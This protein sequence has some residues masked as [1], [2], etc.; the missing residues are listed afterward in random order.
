L[1]LIGLNPYDPKKKLVNIAKAIDWC[2]RFFPTYCLGKGL[3]YVINVEYFDLVFE[4]EIDAWSTEILLIEVIFL[5]LESVLYLVLAIGLDILSS[6]P[7]AM[8]LWQKLFFC[9]QRSSEHSAVSATPDDED[10]VE[11]Q[12]RVLDG[13]ANE[14]VIVMSELTKIYGNGKIAVDK[15]SLGIPPGECFGLLGTNGAG[16]V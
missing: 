10:V 11:E 2:G 12:K 9:F 1:R 7:E 3:L 15:L 14:D 13:N 4:E 6:K 8:L 5:A 16:Y